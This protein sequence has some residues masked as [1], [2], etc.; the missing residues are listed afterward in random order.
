MYSYLSFF[1]LSPGDSQGQYLAGLLLSPKIMIRQHSG[2][3]ALTRC[4]SREQ[5]LLQGA[6]LK[7]QH[8]ALRENMLKR[9]DHRA[10]SRT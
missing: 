5:H 10:G 8:Y 6:D 4:I 1:A 7:R 9:H 2:Q 3:P